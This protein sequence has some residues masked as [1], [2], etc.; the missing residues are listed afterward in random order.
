MLT[1]SGTPDF[2][3]LG[4]FMISPIHYIYITEFVSLRTMFLRIND[5]GLFAWISLDCFVVYLFYSKGLSFHWVGLTIVTEMR[6]KKLYFSEVHE[7]VSYPLYN[8]I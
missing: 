2:T 1:P 6:F 5:S 7:S 3:P 4:K 8:Y